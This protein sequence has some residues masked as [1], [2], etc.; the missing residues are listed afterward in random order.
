MLQKILFPKKKKTKSICSNFKMVEQKSYLPEFPRRKS[1][2]MGSNKIT[3]SSLSNE[4]F[5]LL[6]K[7]KNKIKNLS[8]EDIENLINIIQQSN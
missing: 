3:N 8:N 1:V 4:E 5:V 6:N 2:E 7:L